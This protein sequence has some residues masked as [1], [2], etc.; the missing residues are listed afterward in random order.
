M[1]RGDAWSYPFESPRFLD[2]TSTVTAM[3]AAARRHQGTLSSPPNENVAPPT[4]TEHN[5]AAAVSSAPL[6]PDASKPSFVRLHDAKADSATP[7]AVGVPASMQHLIVHRMKGS[8]FEW[9]DICGVAGCPRSVYT[10]LMIQEM[11]KLDL[12]DIMLEQLHEQVVLPQCNLHFG[13]NMGALVIRYAAPDASMCANSM[14]DLT[15]RMTIV[16]MRKRDPPRVVTLRRL[17]TPVISQVRRVFHDKYAHDSKERLINTLVSRAIRSFM[18]EL[19]LDLERF[20]ILESNLLHRTESRTILA[21]QIYH[22]K[23]RSSAFSHVLG[24]TKHAHEQLMFQFL[25]VKRDC[26]YIGTV[27]QSCMHVK[28]LSDEIDGNARSALEL[29]FQVSNFELNSLIR[30]L[31]MFS[32][33]FAPLGL[34]TGFYGM[35]LEHLPGAEHPYAVQIVLVSMVVVSSLI[36]LWYRY[37]HF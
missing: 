12:P 17:D 13:K 15:N 7:P 22:I 14:Q 10:D 8:S 34:I 26:A 6:P 16:V 36:Q 24:M 5:A 30:V 27:S 23:R 33:F 35:N 25:E 18:H 29:L 4:P 20:D 28:L 21:E 31:T 1:L 3:F 9:V 37:R 2:D 11:S 19:R 32:A